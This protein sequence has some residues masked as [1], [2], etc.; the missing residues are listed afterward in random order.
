MKVLK[1]QRAQH[2]GCLS[3]DVAPQMGALLSQLTEAS[4]GALEKD[5]AQPIAYANVVPG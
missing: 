3:L 5:I 1:I 4:F 2:A